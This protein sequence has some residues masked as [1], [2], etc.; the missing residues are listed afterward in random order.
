MPRTFFHDFAPDDGSP[1]TVEYSFGAG[2]ET[3]YSPMHGA[4]GGDACEI[5]IIDS[6]PNTPEHQH[7]FSEAVSAPADSWRDLLGRIIVLVRLFWMERRARLT[8]AERE[9]MEAWLAEH[10]V[11]EPDDFDD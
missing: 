1:V 3:T 11:D 9:R 2:S 4:C 8:D 10:H 7:L 5:E 6:W